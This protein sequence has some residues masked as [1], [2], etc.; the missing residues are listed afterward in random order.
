MWQFFARWPNGGQPANL[1]A[2]VGPFPAG[3]RPLRQLMSFEAK[4]DLATHY[5]NASEGPPPP[6]RGRRH[7][8]DNGFNYQIHCGKNA[9]R[10]FRGSGRD[11]IKG[12]YWLFVVCLGSSCADFL[13]FGGFLEEECGGKAGE[14]GLLFVQLLSDCL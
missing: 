7:G 1:R 4:R 5:T 12:R 10:V 14:E 6:L 2:R 3:V 8:W 9:G 13:F 11:E